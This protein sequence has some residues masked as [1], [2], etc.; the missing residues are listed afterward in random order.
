MVHR[1]PLI[2]IT[3]KVATRPYRGSTVKP[4]DAEKALETGPCNQLRAEFPR[5]K[6]LK[7]GLPPMLQKLT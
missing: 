4:S 2:A 3:E 5:R 1:S 7:P 6:R